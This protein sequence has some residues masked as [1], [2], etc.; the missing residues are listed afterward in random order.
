MVVDPIPGC[1]ENYMIRML[2]RNRISGL[3]AFQEKQVDGCRKYYYDITSRQPLNRILEKRCLTAAEFRKL[4]S[5]LLFTLRQMERFLLDEGQ[6]CLD[7]GCIYVEPDT[8]QAGFCLVPGKFG[9]FAEEFTELAQY[10]LDHVSHS[11]GEAV[12]VAFAVFREC[13]KENF[14]I[15]DLERCLHGQNVAPGV[16]SDRRRS[17]DTRSN[18]AAETAACP[19]NYPNGGEMGQNVVP[20]GE[21]GAC[22]DKT[23]PDVE[24][25]AGSVG[26]HWGV[27]AAVTGILAVLM[28]AMPLG[29]YLWGGGSVFLRWSKWILVAELVC[30]GAIAFLWRN[31][32]NGEGKAGEINRKILGK[33]VRESDGEVVG[34]ARNVTSEEEALWSIYFREEDEKILESGEIRGGY[35]PLGQKEADSED[36]M[37]TVL[38]TAGPSETEAAVSRVLMPLNGGPEIAIGYYPFLIGKSRDLSDFWLN[39]EGISRLHVKIEK[40]ECGYTVT[41]LNST[42][43][44]GVDGIPLEA[45]ETRELPVGSELRIA[46]TEY[47][48][49]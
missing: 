39:R 11:D 46:S 38:L 36:D 2:H 26:P 24:E 42:N 40:S 22:L 29:I 33:R 17:E 23:S 21:H 31:G 6:L 7:A 19:R 3:L 5:D 15:D 14:G 9:A 48:F 32:G 30:M 28:A 20:D 1:H 18:L 16:E 12:L 41:D 43:G 45:N 49:L 4:I 47:R 25:L 10:L 35:L 13:R 37:Q 34:E 44:T 8:F 27:R